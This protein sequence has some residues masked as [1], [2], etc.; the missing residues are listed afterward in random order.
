MSKTWMT[1]GHTDSELNMI[2]CNIYRKDSTQKNN[3]HFRGGG[4]LI[5][6]HKDINSKVIKSTQNYEYLFV[7]L[8]QAN[9][10]YILY[11]PIFIQNHLQLHIFR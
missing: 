1:N 7:L 3:N 4:V 6:V 5:A 10:Q 2:N 11:V 8:G 9:T